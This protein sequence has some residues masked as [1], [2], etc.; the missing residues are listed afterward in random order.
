MVRFAEQH[1]GLVEACVSRSGFIT[2]KSTDIA[3]LKRNPATA[4]V[5]HIPV[6]TLAAALLDQALNGFEKEILW[7]DD[8]IRL[9][10]S[11]S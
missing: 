5:V 9:G 2:D 6:E 4:N 11:S 10:S 8:L 1:A 3:A 7:T